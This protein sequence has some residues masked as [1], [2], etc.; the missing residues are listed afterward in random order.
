MHLKEK[1][2][3]SVINKYYLFKISIFNDRQIFNIKSFS[4]LGTILS[5]KSVFYYS[6]RIQIVNHWI[7]ITRMR[8][9]EYYNFKVF[10]KIFNDLLS[11]WPYIYSGLYGFTSRK[12]N[13]HSYVTFHFLIFI[14]VNKSFIKVKNQS[15][16]IMFFSWKINSFSIWFVLL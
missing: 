12:M 10:W 9:G 15:F 11:M 4:Q 8:G 2:I 16:F 1:R 5:K 14:T 6:I 7:C 13:F 3:R